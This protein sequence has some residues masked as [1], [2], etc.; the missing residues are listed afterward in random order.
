MPTT[1]A[2]RQ[3]KKD[4]TPFVKVLADV[5]I[6]PGIKVDAGAKDMAGFPGEKVKDSS[7]ETVKASRKKEL[8]E[9]VTRALSALHAHPRGATHK[10]HPQIF[11]ESFSGF[12]ASKV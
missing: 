8:Q 4:G 9:A 7:D 12:P 2:Y 11:P 6:I 3:G 1:R 5:G 10:A